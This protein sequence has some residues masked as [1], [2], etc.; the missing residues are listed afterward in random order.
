[1]KE[2]LNVCVEAL[3]VIQVLFDVLG[4]QQVFPDDVWASLVTSVAPVLSKLFTFFSKTWRLEPE[5]GHEQMA[6]CIETV[7]FS[8][9][10]SDKEDKSYH[11]R[12]SEKVTTSFGHRRACT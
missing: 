11:E 3:Q 1:V 6:S 5:G 9:V 4:G 8:E 12:A 2:V 7:Q 10:S